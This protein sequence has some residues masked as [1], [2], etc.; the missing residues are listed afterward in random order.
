MSDPAHASLNWREIDLLLEELALEGCLVQEIH[1]PSREALV[2]G[3]Y[4]PGG[5]L[6]LLVSLSPR[7]PRV[8]SLSRRMPAS[9]K[10]P[11]FASFLRAH[12]RGGRPIQVQRRAARRAN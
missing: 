11:R 12:L 5:P 4:R 2:L 9:G 7:Y 1:Q 10:P 3:L 8:H 6:S